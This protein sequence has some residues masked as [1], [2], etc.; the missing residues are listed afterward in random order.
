LEDN[1][2]EDTSIAKKPFDRK[3][4]NLLFLAQVIGLAVVAAIFSLSCLV[5]IC[6]IL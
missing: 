1:N 3:M 4:K 6:E 2:I 5:Y